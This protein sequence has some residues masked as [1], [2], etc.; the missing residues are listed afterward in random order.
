MLIFAFY[1]MYYP[2]VNGKFLRKKQFFSKKW[3]IDL[4]GAVIYNEDSL[5]N[6]MRFFFTRHSRELHQQCAEWFLACRQ[7]NATGC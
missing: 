3:R 7:F 1:Q 6:R 5:F 2:R 4:F